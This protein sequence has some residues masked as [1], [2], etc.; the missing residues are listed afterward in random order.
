MADISAFRGI[1][2]NLDL[3]SN[4]SSVVSPP[5]DV[6]SPEERDRL[7]ARD[8]HNVVRIIL[9]R[10]AAGESP[11]DGHARAGE[12]WGVWRRS[13]ILVEDA[14][15]ALYVYRQSFTSPLSGA[16]TSRTAFLCALKLVPY[17]DGVVLPHE[18]TKAA[19]K[20]DRLGLMRA[21]AANV[22]P[23]MGLYED[24]GQRII[25]ALTGA[26]GGTPPMLRADVDGDVHEVWAVTEPHVLEKVRAEMAARRIW[27]ADGHHRYETALNY[28]REYPAADRIMIALIPFE[29]PGLVV[30]P[31]HRIVRGL[32]DEDVD[33]LLG[34]MA[35]RF[36]MA[37][38]RDASD[39]ESMVSGMRSAE[40]SFVV[41]SRGGFWRARLRDDSDL[42]EAAGNRSDAWRSLDVSIL[43]TLVLD[44]LMEG[45]ATEVGYTRHADEAVAQVQAGEAPVAFLVGFPSADDLRAVTSA[46]D[47]M[48]PKSTYFEPKLWS[49]L[50]MRRLDEQ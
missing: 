45:S 3:I 1:H 5:Y 43:Q 47:R 44:P 50:L 6:I 22:E 16:T 48:P 25:G 28:S 49:G 40:G 38:V 29:A 11:S 10:L 42:R 33:D 46:G 13:G 9:Q 2:Y 26:T 23:I 35:R 30:L 20:A 24:P 19:A 39:I 7:Y 15:P 34:E 14:E 31:T 4:L 18:H 8:P 27:I 41:A 21:T 36:E 37:E 17:E 32:T 12:V